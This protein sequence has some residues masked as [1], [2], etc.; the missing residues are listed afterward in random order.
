MQQE[1]TKKEKSI[2]K[3]LPCGGYAIQGIDTKTKQTIQVGYIG[4]NLS[5]DGFF[6]DGYEI[7]K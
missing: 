2:L 7:K 6:P 3:P 5:L 4:K 1:T